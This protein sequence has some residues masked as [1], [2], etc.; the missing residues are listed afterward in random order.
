M[1]YSPR[2]SAAPLKP[3]FKLGLHCEESEAIFF[4][5]GF[6]LSEKRQKPV[7][8]W[9]YLKAT[10]LLSITQIPTLLDRTWSHEETSHPTDYGFQYGR[11]LLDSA[12]FAIWMHEHL[13]AGEKL[14]TSCGPNAYVPYI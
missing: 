2:G 10:V 9:F 14:R 4:C 3:C 6:H 5:L 1:P 12:V 13:T 8:L 11:W 7:R